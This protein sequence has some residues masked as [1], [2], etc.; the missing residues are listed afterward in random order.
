MISSALAVRA[1]VPS[2]CITEHQ[3]KV[4]DNVDCCVMPFRCGNVAAIL[5][6]DEQLN[7]EFTIF[8]AAPQ[9]P[10]IEWCTQMDPQL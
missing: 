8:E 3:V 6:L 5:E 9:C 2:T 1:H 10:T 7:K 4:M